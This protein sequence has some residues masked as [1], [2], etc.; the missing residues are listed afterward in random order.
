MRKQAR[1]FNLFGLRLA[2]RTLFD[3]TERHEFSTGLCRVK[4][5]QKLWSNKGPRTVS[6]GH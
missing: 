5:H 3:N 2:A 4:A 6:E 1:Y